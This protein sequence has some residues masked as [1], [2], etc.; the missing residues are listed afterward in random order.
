MNDIF[1]DD[2]AADGNVPEVYRDVQATLDRFVEINYETA[3]D[4]ARVHIGGKVLDANHTR[5]QIIDVI[6][7]N[8]PLATVPT[9]FRDGRENY[10]W[11]SDFYDD[12]PKD[13]LKQYGKFIAPATP[14]T[15]ANYATELA[16]IDLPYFKEL[17]DLVSLEKLH[18]D[19]ERNTPIVVSATILDDTGEEIISAKEPETVQSTKTSAPEAL[20]PEEP[21]EETKAK[22]SYE[23][24]LNK[25]QYS[26]LVK[27]MNDIELFRRPVTVALLKKLFNG[28][29]TEPLQVTNQH[30]LTYILDGLRKYGYIKYTWISVAAGNKDFISFRRGENIT[31]Y[32]SEQHFL[33]LRQF[34]TS[35]NSNENLG[36]KDAEPIEIAIEKIKECGG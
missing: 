12:V 19:A 25:E 23:P 33:P 20:Q 18:T 14:I 17:I 4:A 9:Y 32:G 28:K 27:C 1:V 10:L 2:S 16:K 15:P 7:N 11:Y 5:Q 29:M 22:R 6:R 13:V 3:C 8:P 36:L 21:S 30:S 31:R 24:K 26:I 35:R 34:T